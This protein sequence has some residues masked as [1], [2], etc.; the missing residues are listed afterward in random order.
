MRFSGFGW[1]DMEFSQK[2]VTLEDR[3]AFGDAACERDIYNCFRLILGRY[4]SQEEWAGH[5]ALAGQ[6]L[7]AVTAKYV[8]SAEYQKVRN[9]GR[10]PALARLPGFEL[11][12]SPADLAVGRHILD[13]LEYEPHVSRVFAEH[14]KPGMNVLDIGANIGYFTFLAA[15]RVGPPGRVWAVEPNPRNVAFL[16]ATRAHNQFR[17]V[18]IIQAAASDRWEVLSLSTDCS[19]GAAL[20]A[21]GRHPDDFPEPVMALPL[22]ACLPRS[23]SIQVVKIDVEGAE[24]KALR[25]MRDL[26]ERDRPIIFSE[27]TPSTLPLVSRI[28]PAEYL[29]LFTSRGYALA[30]LESSGPRY[31]NAAALL[32]HAAAVAAD[33][34]LDILAVQ[35]PS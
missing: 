32:D 30:V 8:G 4:P 1:I 9:S 13:H 6:P 11:Y 25:G 26:V 24:G 12:A 21:S 17:H 18:E 14:L 22:D 15:A 19:N 10:K 29:E 20:E 23:L 33:S 31:L 35:R 7:A 2:M 34:H 3:I 5:R 27:F 28:S 16:S